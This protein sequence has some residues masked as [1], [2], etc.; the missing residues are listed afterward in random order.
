MSFLF[1]FRKRFEEAEKEYISSKVALHEATEKKELLSEHLCTIIQHNEQRKSQKL[2]ELMSALH[3]EDNKEEN[4]N[5]SAVFCVKTPTPGT[6]NWPSNK[7]VNKPKPV[8]P[9]SVPLGSSMINIV[10]RMD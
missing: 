7:A 6:I 10:H 3:I 1:L 8:L 4:C 2:S 9:S 5:N